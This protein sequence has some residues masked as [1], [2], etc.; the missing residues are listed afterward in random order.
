MTKTVGGMHGSGEVMLSEN[1]LAT[2]PGSYDKYDE[3][4]TEL[5]IINRAR[6]AEVSRYRD[7]IETFS[8]NVA[9][10]YLIAEFNKMVKPDPGNVADLSWAIAANIDTE[11]Y[12][13]SNISIRMYFFIKI[14]NLMFCS[15]LLDQL[16]VHLVTLLWYRWVIFHFN[17]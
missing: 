14:I 2:Q 9:G 16:S 4:T 6:W 7:N 13:Y 10:G 11:S 3:G 1:L 8:F 12:S 5:V 17:R 15:F